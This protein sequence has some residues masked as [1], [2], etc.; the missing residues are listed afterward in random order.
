MHIILGGEFNI[1][2]K[3]NIVCVGKVKESYYKEAISE[4]VKRLSRF[5]SVTVKE[6]KEENFAET[7]GNSEIQ[8]IVKKEGEN[9]LKEVKGKAILMDIEGVQYSSQNFSKFLSNFIDKGEETTFIIGGSYGVSDQVKSIVDEK[10]SFSKMTFPHTL[11]RVMLVEQIYRAF[12]IRENS[13]YH[14]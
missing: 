8:T 13:K 14:K 10:I 2:I 1:M 9:I 6:V 7:V 12:M 4:Y 3:I 11:F 5:A